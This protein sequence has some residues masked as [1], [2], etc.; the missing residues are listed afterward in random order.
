MGKHAD[1]YPIRLAIHPPGLCRRRINM[2]ETM[3]YASSLC[4]KANGPLPAVTL[5]GTSSSCANRKVVSKLLGLIPTRSLTHV[6]IIPNTVSGCCSLGI[7][8]KRQFQ[9]SE[10][11]I[12]DDRVLLANIAAKGGTTQEHGRPLNVVARWAK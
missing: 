10:W 6:L 4:T 3:A 7:S 12:L 8:W 11:F 2:H 5:S 1:Q 9:N